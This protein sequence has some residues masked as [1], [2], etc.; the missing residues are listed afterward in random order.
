V[1][2]DLAAAFVRQYQHDTAP[3]YLQV[4]VLAP[5]TTSMLEDERAPRSAGAGTKR[6]GTVPE[7]IPRTRQ[8]RMRGTIWRDRR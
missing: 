4:D 1:L 5:L 3:F 8:L 7:G 6:Y 2:G